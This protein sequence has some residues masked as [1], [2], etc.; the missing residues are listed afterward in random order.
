MNRLKSEIGRI[1]MVLSSFLVLCGSAAAAEINIG[2]TGPLTG[3]S[4][5]F[6]IDALHG[7]L[8][9]AKEVNDAGGLIVA[10]EKYIV[11][12]HPYD[13]EGNAAKALAGMQKLKDRYDTPIVLQNASAC[14]MALLER[15]EQMG[16]LVVG[17][18]RHPEATAKGNKLVL[19]LEGTSVN[20]ARVL[21]EGVMKYV[22]PKSYAVIADVG[23]YGKIY[24][25]YYKNFFEK[26]GVK[27][28]ASE[29]LDMRSQTDFRGQLTKIK[30]GNPDV[31]MIAAYDEATAGVIKQAHELGIKAPFCMSSTFQTVGEK[32]TGPELLEGYYKPMQRHTWNPLPLAIERYRSEL[33][34]KMGFKEPCGPYGMMTYSHLQVI[35]RA[36]QKAGTTTEAM[37]IRQAVPQVVPID[38]EKHDIHG[39]VSISETGDANLNFPMGK[40]HR[41]K[42]EKL[43]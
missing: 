11:K 26:K 12:I 20:E 8:I 42:L 5:Y 16:V 39:F 19:R 10:G 35:F 22:K 24:V 7:T 32:L 29:W 38:Q 3:P 34:P 1:L 2:Y 13:D 33:Y 18:F 40:Y 28:V 17:S 41:G 25:T 6:G 14:I 36:M 30:A 4:A 23:D 15:N 31:V 43:K 37:K 9:A 21:A 27:L